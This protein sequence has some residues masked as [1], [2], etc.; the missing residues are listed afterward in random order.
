MTHPDESGP[1]HEP[2]P[3]PDAP[4]RRAPLLAAALLLAGLGLVP[5]ARVLTGGEVLPQWPGH[6]RQWIVWSVITVLLALLL[7]R[8]G[9]ERLRR[10]L[11]AGDR[12]L[13]AP[14]PRLFALVAAALVT[15][16][17]LWMGRAA[18][19]WRPVSADE[20]AQLWQARILASG[21]LAARTPAHPEFFSTLMTV[22]VGGR[23]FTQFPMGGAAVLALGMLVGATWL[24]NPLLTGLTAAAL[25]TFVRGIDDE[26]T[27]RLATILFGLSPF[28]LLMGGSAM[29][30]V[31]VLAAL[32]TAL[33]ALVRWARSTS[34][35]Q[36]HGAAAAI[37]LALG[38]AATS[39]PY[40]AALVALPIALFQLGIIRRR[41]ELA[42]TLVVQCLVGA[43][44]LALLVA[45]NLS[46]TGGPLRF[47]Y[48]VL[49]G[50]EHRPGFHL[51]PI[52]EEHTPV[53]GLRMLST[54][55]M[56]LNGALFAW[57][58][59]AVALLAGALLLQ[60]R[61]ARWDLLLLAIFGMLL[62]GYGAYWAES[63]FAGPRFLFCA[64]PLFI[65]LV[66]RLPRLALARVRSPAA[67]TVVVLLIPLWIAIAWLLPP[68]RAHAAG[69]RTLVRLNGEK[70][71]LGHQ[72]ARR[73]REA[74]LANAVVFVPDGWHERLAAR[75]RRLHVRPIQAS[76]VATIA[77][78]CFVQTTLDSLDARPD[79]TGERTWRALV[80]ISRDTGAAEVPRLRAADQVSLRPGAPFTP[81]CAAELA[82]SDSYRVSMAELLPYMRVDA[83]GRLAGD[84]IYARDLGAAN[85]RLRG[86]LGSRTWY[87]ARITPRG[88]DIDVQFVPYLPPRDRTNK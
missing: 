86:E 3:S 84:V 62:L 83:E 15:G 70:G 71:T 80:A 25:Y 45:A 53:R 37:G 22:D 59:P 33:A 46:T 81:T 57:P 63:Y 8:L 13:L 29:N 27:A 11:A 21:H 76:R 14:R 32:V 28:V 39:R 31:I 10:A 17:C 51:A 88:N 73:A 44:P 72:V 30:H 69:I 49:N 75:L 52:L 34:Q 36:A 20:L 24:L 2:E 50:P 16:L 4:W 68:N 23:W 48:E 7:A 56:T 40:D 65:L 64:V 85:E 77:D 9:G 38:L 35:R 60:R 19:Q 61:A 26:R 1:A 55:L 82:R 41:P 74:G 12:L 78:A 43:I 58:V 47:G 67:R 6:V 42:R 66:A 79:P 54:Y 18:F 5:V 87:V